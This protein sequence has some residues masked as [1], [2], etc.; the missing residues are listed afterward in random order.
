M[1]PII[2]YSE[3]PNQQA[4]FDAAKQS[5]R[6]VVHFYRPTTRY[7]QVVDAHFER[8]A[9][10]HLETRVRVWDVCMYACGCVLMWGCGGIWGFVCRGSVVRLMGWVD[11]GC[12]LSCRRV[13]GWPNPP[14]RPPTPPHRQFC[15]I[16]AEKAP[17]LVEKLNIFV[18]PTLL[19]IKGGETVKHIRGFDEL[20][21]TDEFSSDMLAYV[22]TQYKVLTSYE[23]GCP[24]EPTG[25]GGG[26][27]GVNSIRMAVGGAGSVGGGG[28][29][30]SSIR[31]GLNEKRYD[32]DDSGDDSDY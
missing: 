24:E 6:V 13:C 11:V 7:C 23:G 32:S 16:N 1:P 2:S 15:K 29:R 27:K 26:G 18:M 20:G 9:P 28:P 8:L 22:L 14:T 19:C 4:F 17:Y 3:L 25:R 30:S 21:G 31:E 12:V 10:R 5:P